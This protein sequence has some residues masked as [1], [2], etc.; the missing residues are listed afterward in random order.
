MAELLSA[1]HE[2]DVAV[3]RVLPDVINV[4]SKTVE[5][6][7]AQHETDIAVARVLPDVNN[8]GAI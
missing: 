5:P 2:T 6:L 8:V 3:A 4:G 1:R 7:S